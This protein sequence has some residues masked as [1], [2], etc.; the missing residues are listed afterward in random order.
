MQTDK[1]KQAIYRL[2]PDVEIYPLNR[3]PKEI[4]SP[5]YQQ[6]HQ[7]SN[8]ME[9]AFGAAINHKKNTLRLIDQN[10]ALLLYSLQQSGVLAEHVLQ[11]WSETTAADIKFLLSMD[12]IEIYIASQK[13]KE[14]ATKKTAGV[15]LSGV[16]VLPFF[17]AKEK[18]SP[19]AQ[20]TITQAAIEHACTLWPATT[21]QL[22]HALYHFNRLPV[23]R[24]LAQQLADRKAVKH[25][26]GLDQ[27]TQDSRSFYQ[28]WQEIPPIAGWIG[29][30]RR[31][32]P[33][34]A[35]TTTNIPRVECKL[36]LSPHIEKIPELFFTVAT[37]LKKTNALQFKI[38][39]NAYGL[40]RP[41]KWVAY[42]SCKQ[43]LWQAIKYLQQQFQSLQGQQLPFVASTDV[44]W[45]SWGQ[46]PLSPSNVSQ[47]EKQA[48]R[49][50]WR[51]FICQEIAHATADFLQQ[52]SHQQKNKDIAIDTVKNPKMMDKL[53]ALITLRLER[54]GID[55][56]T[57]ESN[58]LWALQQKQ[59]AVS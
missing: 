12:L 48:M 29:F 44:A 57:M 55:A 54:Q 1:L 18:K 19:D 42:F 31:I 39:E 28:Q 50:S 45:L 21:T 23:S 25:Y 59:E 30:H 33:T 6:L 20:Q 41:D 43:D 4:D 56:S 14:Q 11:Q 35:S 34:V 7:Q 22:S 3:L 58:H 8:D 40:Q 38:G 26:I 51:G 49:M 16:D 36:Y 15:F 32:M 17:E 24:Q 46:D 52:Q 9:N 27:L 5:L 37:L 2:S 47:G 13:I 10:T 53:L